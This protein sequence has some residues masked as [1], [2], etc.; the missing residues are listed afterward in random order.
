MRLKCQTQ[1][2]Y[3]YSNINIVECENNVGLVARIFSLMGIPAFN[4]LLSCGMQ[5]FACALNGECCAST[6]AGN[7]DAALNTRG[8]YCM[9]QIRFALEH[10]KRLIDIR[11]VEKWQCRDICDMRQCVSLRII[12][13]TIE[14]SR[15]KF[16]ENVI[17]SSRQKVISS[18]SKSTLK[19]TDYAQR[20]D[21]VLVSFD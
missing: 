12:F 6:A 14:I 11:T 18:E 16:F 1:P 9:F 3:A 10:L 8:R 21:A 5:Q 2:Y 15:A 13:R 19:T 17:C 4:W 7:I 20:V